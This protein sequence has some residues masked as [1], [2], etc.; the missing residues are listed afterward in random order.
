[1]STIVQEPA[2]RQRVDCFSV[3]SSA[4]P[5]AL[6]RI[7]EVFSLHGLIP[8]RCHGACPDGGED[9]LVIDIQLS[10]LPS[11]LADQLARRLRRVITVT[12]VLWSQKR[13]A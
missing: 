6:P 9:E 13:A 8:T 10:E 3:F 4:D 1:M 2:A 12:E 5:S 11:G 7:F